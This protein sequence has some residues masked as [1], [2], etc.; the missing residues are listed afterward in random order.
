MAKKAQSISMT[1]TFPS[2]FLTFKRAS[3]LWAKTFIDLLPFLLLWM[4]SQVLLERFFPQ[5]EQ[6]STRFFVTLFLDMAITALFFGVIL[7]GLYQRYQAVP[8]DFM[9]SLKAGVKRFVPL[10]IAYA[11]I[12]LPM[13]LVL[14]AFGLLLH[15]SKLL[16]ITMLMNILSMQHVVIL[17]AAFLS[18]ALIVVYFMAG[19]FIVVFNDNVLHA[20]KQSYQ[21]VKTYW[22]DTLLVVVLFGIIATFAMFILNEFSIPYAKA[23]LTLLLSSFYPALMIIHY[24]NLVKHSK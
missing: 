10:F 6:I 19:V 24:E 5:E 14:F 20:F 23:V 3:G 11:L 21:L 22:M 8:F 13:L 1:N 18:L 12:S 16:P 17:T 7:S 9:G 2:L 15:F 4:L